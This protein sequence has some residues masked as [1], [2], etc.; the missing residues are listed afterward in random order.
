MFV[1]RYLKQPIAID[2]KEKM[3]FI[4]GPRQVGK[5]TLAKTFLTD[6]S[7]RYFNWDNRDDRREILSARWPAENAI[8]IFDELHKYKNWK[9]WIKGEYDKNGDRIHFLI[10]GSAR[11]DIYRK[12]GDS[13]QGRYHAHRLHGFSV[14]ELS[15]IKSNI[16]IGREIDFPSSFDQNLLISLFHYGPFPEPFLKQNERYLRRWQRE[17]IDRFF[18]EDVRDLE[19]IRDLSSMELLA[20]MLKERVGS[21]FSF[22]SLREDLEVSHK[23]ISH[24]IDVF[25]RLYFCFI[26]PPFTGSKIRSL[27]KLPKLYLW[28]WSTIDDK[29][30]RFENLVA[31]HLLKM[32]HALEDQEGFEIGL[33]YL[34]DTSKREVDF[35]ITNEDKPWFAVECKYSKSNASPSLFYFGERLSIPYLYQV[36]LEGEDDVYD[37]RVRVMPAAKFLGSLP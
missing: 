33:Y 11:L 29:G 28:D 12:G 2:L 10:T 24:W 14:G 16:E 31:C 37:G 35:L 30:A 23:A 5:T 17:R 25:E 32:K 4:S 20:D 6:K 18:R 9:G 7:D 8:I 15:N 34:R 36:S 21:P 26:V 13:L 27:K 1:E 19:S 22:Q 3:V